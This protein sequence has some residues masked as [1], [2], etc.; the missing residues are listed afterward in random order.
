MTE[1]RSPGGLLRAFRD[2][3][4]ASFG[5][6]SYDLAP[7]A[8]GVDP[9]TLEST[10]ELEGRS[11]LVTDGRGPPGSLDRR[12]SFMVVALDRLMRNASSV[13][14]EGGIVFSS[15]DLENP[16]ALRLLSH[17]GVGDT[18]YLNA[19][20]ER[21]RFDEAIKRPRFPAFST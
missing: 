3:Y 4:V 20:V 8:I 5:G 15:F 21:L 14:A 2:R 11:V 9:Q 6:F 17:L 13:G 10:P 7:G 1:R 12:P 16:R 18:L 19:A